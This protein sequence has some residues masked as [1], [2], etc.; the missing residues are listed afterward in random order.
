MDI[1]DPQLQRLEYA[2]KAFG[3]EAYLRVSRAV[4]T[5][6]A[7]V[8][9]LLALYADG[10]SVEVMALRA[11]AVLTAAATLL[12][13][14][15]S[16]CSRFGFP[17]AI[18]AFGII[19]VVLRFYTEPHEDRIAALM[20]LPFVAYCAYSGFVYAFAYFTV[21]G[22]G[23]ENERMRI[24]AWIRQLKR[25]DGLLPIFEFSS[26]SFW[27]GYFTY[28]F[29][30]AGNYWVVAR[31]KTGKLHRMLECRLL[32]SSS[33]QI[34]EDASGDLRVEIDGRPIPRVRTS[35]EM[36]TNILRAVAD[37]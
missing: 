1:Q 26:G 20:F 22:A 14:S 30:R 8:A 3:R 18:L 36:R 11:V 34:V 24:K 25:P 19:T 27:T 6:L 10:H 31:F 35:P 32:G 28:R 12:S 2:A 7:A 37:A 29:L 4:P 33:V 21:E 17:S 13:W 16:R 23:W 15:S 5:I 9:I